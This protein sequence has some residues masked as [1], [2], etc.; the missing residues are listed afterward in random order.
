MKIAIYGKSFN[1]SFISCIQNLFDLLYTESVEIQVFEPFWAFLNARVKVQ[2]DIEL[3]SNSQDLT[4]NRPDFLFSIGGDGTFID[5]VH[6]AYKENIP[7]LGINT[8]RLGFLANI[9]KNNITEALEALFANDFKIEKRFLLELDTEGEYFEGTNFA[10][11]E[12]TVQK[13]DSSSMITL[14]TYVNGHYL[15]SYWADGLIISTPTGST[16]YSLSCGGPIVIP[17][18]NNFLITPIAP[19]NLTARPIVLPDE[20]EITLKLESRSSEVLVALDSK[21]APVTVDTTLTIRRSK[22]VIH[23]V[24]LSSNNF[25]DTLRNKLLWGQDNRN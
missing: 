8:G 22:N 9:S 13:K 21:T 4:D 6:Y 3:F 2:S 15:S 18:S 20:N 14:H 10:L 25:Y 12:L 19:H 17:Q 11:N 24:Q 1:E 7:M 23:L 5:C 16:A